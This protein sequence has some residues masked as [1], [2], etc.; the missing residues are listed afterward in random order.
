MTR[1]EKFLSKLNNGS[2]LVK[3]FYEIVVVLV[4]LWMFIQ[5]R[6]FPAVYVSKAEAQLQKQEQKCEFD[7]LYAKLNDIESYLRAKQC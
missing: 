4:I 7:R 3:I 6:D 1:V 5:V 2:A